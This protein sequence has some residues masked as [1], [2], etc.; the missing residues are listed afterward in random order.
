M[1]AALGQVT[2][3]RIG[4]SGRGT[5]DRGIAQNAIFNGRGAARSDRGISLDSFGAGGRRSGGGALHDPVFRRRP[6]RPNQR[7]TARQ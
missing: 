4:N 2:S 1:P 7:G 3:Q 5:E 6:G